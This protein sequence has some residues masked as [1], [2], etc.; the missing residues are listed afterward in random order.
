M[1]MQN[2]AVKV[3]L[4][5]KGCGSVKTVIGRPGLGRMTCPTACDSITVEGSGNL[6][7]RDPFFIEDKKCKFV[8]FQVL[9]LQVTLHISST[10]M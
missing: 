6:C 9:K 4:K 1:S 3:V 5:C 10:M 7:G 2:R 8:D